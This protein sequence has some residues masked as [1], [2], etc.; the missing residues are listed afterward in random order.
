MT[1][2]Q[3]STGYKSGGF[4][5][6]PLTRSQVTTFGPEKLTAYEVGLKSEWFEHRLRAN[7]AGF[8]S[9]YKDLQLPVATVDPGT[10]LPAFLTESVG[11]ATIKGVELETELEPV[12]GLVL[13]GSVGYLDYENDSLGG[14]AYNSVTN[15]SGPT[16]GDKPPL[17]PKWKFNVGAQYTGILRITAS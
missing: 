15:P 14:A 12:P 10:G 13:N 11:H 2:A 9:E 5:P 3:W 8:V 7:F 4:N 16:L 6:R 17:T 1:Y